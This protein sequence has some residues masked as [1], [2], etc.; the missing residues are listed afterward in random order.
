MHI[1][2]NTTESAV[3]PA[4]LPTEPFTTI[5]HETTQKPSAAIARNNTGPTGL[6]ALDQPAKI[7]QS[8]RDLLPLLRAQGTLYLAAHIYGKAYLITKGDTVRLPSVMKDVEPGDTLRLN[9]AL[10]LGSRD[11]TL[12]PAASDSGFDNPATMQ[13]LQIDVA[14]SDSSTL[15]AAPHF[16]PHIAK[17]KHSYIDDRL[18]VCRALVTGVES[19]P[20]R[21]KE[22]TKRRQRHVKHV[23]SKHRYTI[24]KIAE[25][26]VRSLE[27]IDSGQID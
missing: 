19:E 25:L 1:A 4:P 5:S 8:V 23:R 6:P 24:L 11:L 26:R 13:D 15:H 10:Y 3:V 9:R 14:A 18:F 21:I 2:S 27:E 17:N 12:K 22:K 16:I 20:M 7:S